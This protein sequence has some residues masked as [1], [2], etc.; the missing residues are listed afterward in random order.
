MQKEN[1]QSLK[2]V[3]S[4]LFQDYRLNE[5]YL[6]AQAKDIWAELLG[7]RFN[8]YVE[9]VFVKERKLVVKITSPILRNELE[10]GK[11]LTLNEIHQTMKNSFIIEIKY[12]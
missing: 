1:N 3:L 2:S 11:S 7:N 5:G 12:L 10:L 8:K 4:Q 9:D 6:S